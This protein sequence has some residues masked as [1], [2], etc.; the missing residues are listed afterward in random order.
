VRSRIRLFAALVAL[1][2]SA[3]CVVASA[4]PRPAH[5]GSAAARVAPAF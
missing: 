5:S 2:L 1:V 4:T 3:L